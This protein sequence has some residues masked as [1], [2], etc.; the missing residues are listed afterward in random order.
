MRRKKPRLQARQTDKNALRGVLS[1]R[2]NTARGLPLKLPQQKA[3]PRPPRLA[4]DGD[5]ERGTTRVCI[6]PLA[7]AL[8]S[9]MAYRPVV[10]M[11]AGLVLLLA[12]VWW[13]RRAELC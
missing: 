13:H 12:Y 10:D 2:P 8:S 1:I 5:R 4:G 7:C 11:V 3:P 9:L 6:V